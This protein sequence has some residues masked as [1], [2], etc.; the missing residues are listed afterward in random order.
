[1]S[2]LGAA[3]RYGMRVVRDPG[4]LAQL[5][6][7]NVL[8]TAHLLL[9]PDDAGVLGRLF[10]VSPTDVARL[11]R[12]L[13]DDDAFRT[14]IETRWLVIRG[15]PMRLFGPTSAEDEVPHARLLY[16]AVRLQ[17]PA[18][19]VETGVLDG[20]GTAFLLKALRDN[21]TG[22]LCS[23]DLPA[24][25]PVA[26]STDRMRFGTL[27]HGHE[28]GWLVPDD[29]R[30]RWTLRTGSSR[31]VLPGWLGELGTID[32]FVHDSLHTRA[33]MTWEL[34]SAWPALAR[35]GLLVSDDV[36]WNR[37]FPAFCRRQ[38]VTGVIA[39]GMGFARRP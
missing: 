4:R 31:D 22:R 2:R 9:E 20:I 39:R 18:V 19:V 23:I 7:S 8:A 35:G 27:P 6:Y 25:R 15:R 28:P 38:R 29:L 10:P 14:T 1:M 17:R 33:H 30:A 26:A 36:F 5:H 21:G 13:T 11:D 24:R 16:H 32:V 12:D 37:A 34:M 3:L